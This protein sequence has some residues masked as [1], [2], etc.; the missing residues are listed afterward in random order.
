MI[1]LY[2]INE[3]TDW[4][5]TKVDHKITKLGM[6]WAKLSTK[7]VHKMIMWKSSAQLDIELK[8]LDHI[9][10]RG[11]PK[12]TKNWQEYKL[13]GVIDHAYLRKYVVTLHV[14]IWMW[15][16]SNDINWSWISIES[17]WGQEHLVHQGE[18]MHE[19]MIYELRYGS[20][21]Q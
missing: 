4:V 9:M 19:H 1:Q 6:T 5:I 8:S 7:C 10:H 20:F 11:S 2:D 14:P 16:V 18:H 13:K 12:T 15:L 21:V 3:D 17:L